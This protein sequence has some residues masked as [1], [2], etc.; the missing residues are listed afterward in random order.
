MEKFGNSAFLERQDIVNW[1]RTYL[2]HIKYYCQQGRL[3]YYF[4]KTWINAG[5][6]T[7][8]L[9][10]E[11]TVTTP[12]EIFSRGPGAAQKEPSGKEKILIARHI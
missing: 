5:E 12:Q 2:E 3:I 8:K 4:D 11:N 6:T 1:R 7:A 10:I 9:W